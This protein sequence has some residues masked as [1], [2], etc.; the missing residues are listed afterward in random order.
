MNRQ[1]IFMRVLWT[2][3]LLFLLGLPGQAQA[4][5]CRKTGSVCT[6]GPSTK[7]INGTPVYRACWN[8]R[9][10]YECVQPNYIDYCAGIRNTWGCTQTSSVCSQYAFNGECLLYTNRF[11]CGDPATPS[12]GVVLLDTTHTIVQDTIN[13][14][15][16]ASLDSNASCK[17]AGSVCTE[18]GGYRTINGMQVYKDCWAWRDDYTCVAN[19]YMNYCTPLRQ[20]GCTEVAQ[21]CKE[22]A[23]NGQ[24]MAYERTYSC[25][26]KMATPLP[27]NVVYLDS[28]YTIIRDQQNTAQCDPMANNPNCTLAKHTCTQGP[29]TRNINGLDVYKD[30]WEWEDEYVCASA[31]VNSTCADLLRDPRCTQTGERCVDRLPDGT[32]GMKERVFT[33]KVKDETT[34]QQTVCD[35]GICVDGNCSAP[36]TDNDTDMTRAVALMEGAREAGVYFD[37][38]TYTM[39]NGQNDQCSRKLGGMV[40]CCGVEVKAAATNSNSAMFGAVMLIGNEAVRYLGSTYVYD[41]LFT[42]D[43]LPTS[44]LN[45]LYGSSAGSSYSFFGNGSL[46]F[47]G[48]T[49]NPGAA[50]F[51]EAFSFNPYAFVAAIAIQIVTEF[52]SCEPPEMA[53]ALKKGQRLCTHVG[54]YCSSKFLGACIEKKES[55]CC[56]NSRLSRI[57]NEQGRPQIGKAYGNPEKPDC[58]GFTASELERLDFGAMDLSEFFNEIMPKDFDT[59]KFIERVTNKLPAGY[60][61]GAYFPTEMSRPDPN[62]P[63]PVP[64]EEPAP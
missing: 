24:C 22:T 35:L 12:T 38:D 9:D 20:S 17:K 21:T 59:D 53:L 55:Y 4:A 57:I 11:R 6:D 63:N 32:C 34:T 61:G 19:D 16:C 18:P 30:C 39:F 8:Y 3:A 49:F 7:T 27:T 29:G 50:T 1:S 43:F 51:A 28:S 41:A 48:I 33:C 42:S 37:P 54:S 52:L 56:Y 44:I 25:D 23:W 47:Y 10:T 31:P 64:P 14:A 40:S 15:P 45:M 5:E 58:A 60:E 36:K 26:A 2:L 62:Y 13:R 46:S